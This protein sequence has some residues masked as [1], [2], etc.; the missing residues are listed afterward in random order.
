MARKLLR[1]QLYGVVL[2]GEAFGRFHSEVAT[3]AAHVL[4]PRDALVEENN[5]VLAWGASSRPPHCPQHSKDLI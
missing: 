2:S 4:D 5:H 1:Y 3:G